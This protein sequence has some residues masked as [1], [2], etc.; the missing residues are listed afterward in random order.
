L[1]GRHVEIAAVRFDLSA[2]VVTDIEHSTKHGRGIGRRQLWP[3]PR[4][5]EKTEYRARQWA[6]PKSINS[7]RTTKLSRV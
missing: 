4:G 3:A 5:I 7:G 6:H 1:E 2:A